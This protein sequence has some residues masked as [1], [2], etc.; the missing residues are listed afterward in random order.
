MKEESFD[1]FFYEDRKILV[2]KRDNLKFPFWKTDNGSDKLSE[3]RVIEGM[4]YYGNS[5]YNYAAGDNHHFMR[6]C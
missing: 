2:L 5:V 3:Q 6:Q 4:I 1:W